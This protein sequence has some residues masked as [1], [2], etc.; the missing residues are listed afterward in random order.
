MFRL[1]FIVEGTSDKNFYRPIFRKLL[2]PDI[3]FEITGCDLTSKYDDSDNAIEIVNNF[4][5]DKYHRRPFK[6]NKIIMLTDIDAC[7]IASKYVKKDLYSDKKW[8]DDK[9]MYTCNTVDQIL[10]NKKKSINLQC[11]YN[12]DTVYDTDFEIYYNCINLEHV[13]H[14]DANVDN[15]LKGSKA[16]EGSLK[17]SKDV[18]SFLEFLHNKD[19]LLSE[20]YKKSWYDLEIDRNSLKR[21]TNLW[22]FFNNHKDYFND[23]SENK[24]N[25]VVRNK[26][27][28][29]N[30]I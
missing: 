5:S 2:K 6:Y 12:A 14:N 27:N 3:K 22:I 21:L 23:I 4:L 13:Y 30:V 20:D 10:T 11:L 29:M 25:H 8:Y 28:N 1:L 24:H 16:S 9:Y 19:I 26:V 15:S 17:Y 18:K 7:F